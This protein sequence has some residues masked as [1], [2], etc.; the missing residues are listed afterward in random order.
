KTNKSHL[1]EKA[2]SLIGDIREKDK[3]IES[4]E[5]KLAVDQTKDILQSK[6]AIKGVSIITHKLENMD[7][8]ALRGLGD[9]IRN[10]LGSGVIV[11][12]SVSDNKLIFLSMVTKDL[13]KEGISA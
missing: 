11:L 8:N 9:E 2:K 7:M 5:D 10:Q 1:Y 6:T 12:A 13:V 3:E 4:L